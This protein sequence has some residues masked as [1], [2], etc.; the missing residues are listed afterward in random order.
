NGVVGVLAGDRRVR[1]AVEIRLEPGADQDARLALLVCLPADERLDVGMVEVETDHLRRAARR[2]P[3]LDRAG[4]SITDLEEGHESR[5]DAAARER[6]PLAA[7]RGEVRA[8]ARSI[9]EETRLAHP[10]VHDPAALDEVIAHRLD[11][12]G[13][14][15]RTAVGVLRFAHGLGRGIDEVVALRR[16]GD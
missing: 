2:A 10:E 11:E 4:R 16:S 13:V 5:R 8:R 14:G 15:L 6:L 9:L 12:A 1:L 7:D 3:A